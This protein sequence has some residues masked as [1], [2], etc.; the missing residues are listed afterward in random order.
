M[1]SLAAAAVSLA[2]IGAPQE[3][4]DAP[5]RLELSWIPDYGL[6]EVLTSPSRPLAV[7]VTGEQG[8]RLVPVPVGELPPGARIVEARAAQAILREGLVVAFRAEL[9]GTEADGRVHTHRWSLTRELLQ[10]GEWTVSP[11]L[12]PPTADPFRIVEVHADA[13][14]DTFEIT[15]R[16]GTAWH[17]FEERILAD[18]CG[19]VSA[20]DPARRL[21]EVT[22]LTRPSGR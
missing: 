11:D 12:F 5:R 14:K 16:R 4:A 8:E 15:F 7:R 18:E 1:K 10:G 9:P 19:G 21:Y 3:P 17:G 13:D 6:V 22:G 20:R 2:L